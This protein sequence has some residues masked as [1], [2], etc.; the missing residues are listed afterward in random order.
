MLLAVLAHASRPLPLSSWAVP[1]P[2]PALASRL[3]ASPRLQAADPFESAAWPQLQGALD[4][5][6]VFTVANQE[7]KPLQYEI[8]GTP[9]A[10]FY[11]DVE[12]AKME[13]AAA[14]RQYP[15]IGC[16][17]IPVGLGSAYRL[18][19]DGKAMLVPG[20]AELRAAGAPEDAQPM[21]QDLPLFAC[22]EMSVEGAEG[23]QELP[24]FLSYADC[25][26]A[27]GRT[28]DAD[29]D[30][31]T[32]LEISGLSLPSVVERLSSLAEPS[33]GGFSFQ[34][35]S[36]SM[37][38]IDAYLGQGVYWRDVTDGEGEGGKGDAAASGA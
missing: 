22:M 17:L 34:A 13:L 23:R 7:G 33:S 5:L 3:A 15:D 25:Q 21:G 1:V 4:K 38:H 8:Q 18:S 26:A 31:E 6:P 24:L 11:A 30:D 37:R 29:P 19:C 20:V 28:N 35:P 12:A 36:A 27:V 14:Q 9:L 2:L 10:V 32:P 16:D